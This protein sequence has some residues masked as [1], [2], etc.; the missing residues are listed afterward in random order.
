MFLNADSIV[1]FG[2]EI[3]CALVMEVLTALEA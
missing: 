3:L 1:V 2:K